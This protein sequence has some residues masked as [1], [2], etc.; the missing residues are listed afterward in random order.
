METTT[1]I[2]KY[3]RDA[4]VNKTS[5]ALVALKRNPIAY[6]WEDQRCWRLWQTPFVS[7]TKP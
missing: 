3:T 7:E 2:L 6:K 5:P 4:E 1:G